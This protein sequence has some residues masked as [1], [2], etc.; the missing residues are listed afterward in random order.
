LI[1]S[2]GKYNKITSFFLP[3]TYVWLLIFFPHLPLW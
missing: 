3:Y 2:V 1:M